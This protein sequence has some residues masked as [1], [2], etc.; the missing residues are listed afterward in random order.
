MVPISDRRAPDLLTVIVKR[1]LASVLTAWAAVSFTFLTLRIAA[2]DPVASL[3]SRGLASP[4]DVARLRGQLGLDQ[5]LIHQ[6]WDFLSGFVRGDLGHSLYSNRPVLDII[7]EQLPA[8]LSLALLALAFTVILAALMGIGAAWWNQ[9]L[10]GRIA[11]LL[12]GT[13][14]AFPVIFVATIALW[15]VRA[16]HVTIG[17][18]TRA[19]LLTL[20]MPALVLAFSTAGGIAW[21]LQAGLL[22]SMRAP[23]FLAARARGVGK[24][25]LLWHALKPA[26]PPVVSLFALE[27]AFLFTGTVVTETIF[28]RP[29][30]GRLLVQSVLEGDYPVAQGLVALAAVVYTLSNGAADIAAAL[31]DPRIRRQS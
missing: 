23:Y 31:L 11:E 12:S 7:L 16:S 1:L 25:S 30:L 20:L 5:P 15:L 22:E 14:I 18:T 6:Y 27:A 28:A 24:R 3:L 13:A 4:S 8:T 21:T 2:G 19:G 9:R 10:A 17:I 26:L 29:G